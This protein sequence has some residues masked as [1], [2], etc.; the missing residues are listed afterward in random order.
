MENGRIGIIGAMDSEVAGF[1]AMLEGREEQQV[2]PF[3]FTCGR[4]HGRETVIVKCGEGKVAAAACATAMAMRFH[5]ACIINTGVAG[6]VLAGQGMQPLDVV[7]GTKVA[8]HDADATALGYELGRIPSQPL[9][10]ECSRSISDGLAAAAEEALETKVFR[11]V[12]ASGDQ[13]M[14]DGARSA[15]VAQQFGAYAVDMESAAIGQACHMFEIPFGIVRALSDCAD[16]KA[17]LSFTT[18]VEKAAGSAIAL[19]DTYIRR[20]A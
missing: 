5:P 4:I 15:A 8:H 12:V 3:Q 10:F 14:A 2:G 18:L 11:G 20:M 16:S 7:I 1:K 9:Y 6:G 19:I 17:S 13:F